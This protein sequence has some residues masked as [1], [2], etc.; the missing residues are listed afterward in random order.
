MCRA[1]RLL[2]GAGSEPGATGPAVSGPLMSFHDRPNTHYSGA[3][4]AIVSVDSDEP[5]TGVG[6]P[7]VPPVAPAMANAVFAAT[8]RRLT[9]LPLKLV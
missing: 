5:P 2:R 3:R 7:G 8:G 6:E 4:Y 9:G 1:R